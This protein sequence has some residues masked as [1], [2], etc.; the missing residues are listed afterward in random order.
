[1][2]YDNKRLLAAAVASM[3]SPADA[4]PLPELV[5]GD[6]LLAEITSAPEHCVQILYTQVDRDA[7]GGTRFSSFTYAPHGEVYFYP[8]STVKLPVALLALAKC[9]ALGIPLDAAMHIGTVEPWQTEAH[10]PGGVARYVRK[11]F[12]VSDNDAYNRLL[13]FVGPDTV[14]ETFTRQGQMDTRIFHRVGVARAPEH[15]RFSNPVTFAADGRTIYSEPAKVSEGDFAAEVPIPIGRGHV[16]AGR[17]VESPKDFAAANAF[18]LASQQA[19]LRALVLPDAVTGEERFALGG[20][21]RQ[22]VLAAMVTLPRES[23]DPTYPADP[24]HDDFGKFLFPP[25]GGH[26]AFGKS[27]L[28]YGFVVDNIYFR[29]PSAGI[30]FFLAATVYANA[31]G[32]LNDDLYEYDTVAKP[33]MR[34]LGEAVLAHERSRD[35]GSRTTLPALVPAPEN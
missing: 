35:P 18:P 20:A 10:E 24:F 8:A 22:L 3:I 11:I 15:F 5:A 34:R 32:V 23:E 6:P 25:S 28:A 2:F 33:F 4:N 16:D 1:M 14:A 9:R 17:L 7:E 27:G 19:V 12:L 30:D 29:E 31:D 13:E 26:R 21:E